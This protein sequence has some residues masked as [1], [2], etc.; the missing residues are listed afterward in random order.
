MLSVAE[1]NIYDIQLLVFY[2]LKLTHY[3]P[4]TRTKFKALIAPQYHRL[5]LPAMRRENNIKR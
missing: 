4:K 1:K 3:M 5:K 2:E